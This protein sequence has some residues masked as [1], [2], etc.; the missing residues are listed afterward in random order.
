MI[1]TTNWRERLNRDLKRVT[2]MRGAFPNPEATILLLGGVAMSRKAYLRKV[3][4][5]R[6]ENEKFESDAQA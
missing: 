3:P 1:Y 5:M 2:R 4:K 6:N